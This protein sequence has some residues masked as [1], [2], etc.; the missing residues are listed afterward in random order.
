MSTE[1]H[2][3]PIALFF[4]GQGSQHPGMGIDYYKHSPRSGEVF[5]RADELARIFNLGYS[6]TELCFEDPKEELRGQN[7]NTAKIQP[8]LLTVGMAIY[9]HLKEMGLKSP[10]YVAG[11][12]AGKVIA[13]VASGAMNFDTGFE[14]MVRR[15][16][17][18]RRSTGIKEGVV[19]VID[20]TGKHSADNNSETGL[21]GV[22][23]DVF[24]ELGP[25]ASSFRASVENSVN[26]VMVSGLRSQ[27]GPV[28][29]RLGKIP[30]RLLEIYE[31]APV[32]HNP[33]IADAQQGFNDFIEGLRERI[34][35][36]TFPLIDDKEGLVIGSAAELVA[37]FNNHLIEPISWRKVVL[38][39]VE[40]G[41]STG[42]E[43]GPG[44]VLRGI[45]TRG[46]GME[47]FTTGTL[48]E[49]EIAKQRNTFA[50]S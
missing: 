43:V 34:G 1:M 37:S 24:T 44:K 6:I 17:S 20:T 7:A 39:A 9:E 31:G 27:A 5:R 22:I 35:N 23:Q 15:G 11:H 38:K 50:F 36:L 8:A 2:D 13:A 42:F 4:P 30:H 3:K 45:S 19:G 40:G 16:E 33:M 28:F 29:E 14:I 26:Q 21:L 46:T 18:M 47:V 41:V 10:R 12:S 32:S 49:A 48:K 25:L